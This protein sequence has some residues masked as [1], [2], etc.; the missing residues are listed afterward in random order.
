MPPC[1]LSHLPLPGIL[2]RRL[3]GHQEPPGLSWPPACNILTGNH[4]GGSWLRVW[5][6]LLTH[7]HTWLHR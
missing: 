5:L 7:L 3:M 1:A 6:M 4:E 2:P